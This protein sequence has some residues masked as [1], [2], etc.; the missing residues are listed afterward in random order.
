MK[1]AGI[2]AGA[3]VAVAA[4][5]AA[6]AAQAA[7]LLHIE[8]GPITPVPGGMELIFDSAGGAAM[9][10]F[11]IIGFK[12]LDGANVAGGLADVFT[13]RLNGMEVL[14][15][16]WNLGG[17]G[18][19][20]VFLADVAATALAQTPGFG[21]G[22]TVDITTPLSLAAGANTLSF[23]FTTD[24]PQGPG[25]ESWALGALTVDGPAAARVPEPATWAVM[26]LGFA[27]LGG[28]LRRNRLALQK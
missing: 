6:V 1:I 15:G 14:R 2:L 3:S 17:G 16:A 7:E 18:Q 12:T 20:I 11:Q 23:A 9:V 10:K 13:L 19:N 22:G 8:G 4:A 26:L 27:G 28:A 25:D 5:F 24:V 21:Q